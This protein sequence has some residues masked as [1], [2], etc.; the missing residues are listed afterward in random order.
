MNSKKLSKLIPKLH[1]DLTA[2]L[3]DK[4][5]TEYLCNDL[6]EAVAEASED[7]NA[8]FTASDIHDISMNLYEADKRTDGIKSLAKV[9]KMFKKE[10]LSM[11]LIS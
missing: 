11:F 5:L 9:R 6:F 1:A 8:Y 3:D 7:G 4:N 10:I 2:K